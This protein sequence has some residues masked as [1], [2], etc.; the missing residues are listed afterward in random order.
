M[1]MPNFFNADSSRKRR[2]FLGLLA[3]LCAGSLFP[4]GAQARGHLLRYFQLH[5]QTGVASW[6]GPQEA[7][8]K[9][10]SGAIFDPSKP[11]A[12]HRTLPLGTCMRVTRL[13]NGRS[14]LVP[15]TDRGPYVPGRIVDLSEAA[16]RALDV[17]DAGLAQVRLEFV[18]TCKDTRA[19]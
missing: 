15:V 5:G 7:G 19:L 6:Y 9:T 12:A 17:T 4:D 3:A 11:T 1:T 13:Q 14:I 18:P 10:A 2:I 8:R 16:A